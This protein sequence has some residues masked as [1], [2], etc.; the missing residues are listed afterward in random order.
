V[1]VKESVQKL[2]RLPRR[3]VFASDSGIG[4]E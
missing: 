3:S 2:G 4:F 1:V